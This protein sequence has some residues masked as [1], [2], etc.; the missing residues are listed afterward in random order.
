MVILVPIFDAYLSVVHVSCRCLRGPTAALW[1]SHTSVLIGF[2]I[3]KPISS[4]SIHLGDVWLVYS[5]CRGFWK[6]GEPV[7]HQWFN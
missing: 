4:L 5:Y 6:T 1:F 3:S 2:G 7:A